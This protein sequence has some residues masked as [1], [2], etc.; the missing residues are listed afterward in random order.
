MTLRFLKFTFKAV[1]AIACALAV[2]EIVLELAVCRNTGTYEHKSLGKVKNKGLFIWGEEGYCRL[3]INS[4]GMPGYE[5]G[6]KQPGEFRILVL[7]DSFTEAM[8]L[9]L[10]E[11]YPRLLEKYL[12][13]RISGNVKVINAARAGASPAYYIHLAD[14]YNS[15]LK[16][17]LVIV[18]INQSDFDG[19]MLNPAFNFYAVKTAAGFKTI[20][21]SPW[22]NTPQLPEARLLFNEKTKFLSR[23]SVVSRAMINISYLYQKSKSGDSLFAKAPP[24]RPFDYYTSQIDW[25]LKTLKSLYSGLVVLDLPYVDY[26]KELDRPTAIEAYIDR[27]A[28]RQGITIVKLR[29]DFADW[30]RTREQPPVGF[31][32]TNPWSGHMNDAG[33]EIAA[34]RLAGAIASKYGK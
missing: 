13:G 21:N 31:F 7:G 15:V 1:L 19:D 20:R 10:E 4:M 23:L 26:R 24:Q 28:E 16:P 9:P 11:S 34:R 25:A 6:P 8:N 14:F 18:Q 5:I 27:S 33:H 29:R 32:N 2:W 3:P 22:E 30:Y 12:S 17:D